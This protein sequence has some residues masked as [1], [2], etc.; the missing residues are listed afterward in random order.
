MSWIEY[1]MRTICLAYVE[2]ANIFEDSVYFERPISYIQKANNKDYDK[3]IE[4]HS[5]KVCVVYH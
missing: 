5:S 2:S 1:V 3:S 4:W